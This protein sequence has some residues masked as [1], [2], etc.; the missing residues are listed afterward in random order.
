[1][2]VGGGRTRERVRDT[3]IKRWV[4]GRHWRLSQMLR[5]SPRY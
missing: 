4:A 3:E 1:M 5:C 2:G